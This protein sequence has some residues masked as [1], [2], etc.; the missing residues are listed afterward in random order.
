MK[1][2]YTWTTPRG[3]KVEIIVN[4][5]H[6]TKDVINAD[7]LPVEIDCDKWHRKI[8][9]CKVNGKNTALKELGQIGNTDCVIID[10]RGDNRIAA[11]IPADIVDSIYGE[12]RRANAEKI[13]KELELADKYEAHCEMMRKAMSY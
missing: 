6:I 4:I 3:A 8:E 10:R 5:E 11:E 2:T 13:K 7:G 1:N 9:S 12:E